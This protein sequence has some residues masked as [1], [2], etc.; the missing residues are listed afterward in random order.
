MAT[1]VSLKVAGADGNTTLRR[2]SAAVT[3]AIAHRDDLQIR[4]IV[5]ALGAPTDGSYVDDPLAAMLETA[6]ANGITVVVPSGNLG[7]GIVT[8]P[9]DDAWLLTTGASDPHATTATS[10][11]T[12]AP[13]SGS[14]HLAEGP[15]PDVVA[16][17]VSLLSLRAPG[18]TID[19]RHPEGRVDTNLFRGSGTS[20]AVA[21]TGGAAALVVQAHPDATP[22]DVKGALTSSADPIA[23]S[24]LGAVDI[25]AAI[26][27]PASPAWW[28]HHPYALGGLDLSPGEGMPWT[29]RSWTS[30]S[31]TSRSWTS[32]SWTSRSWTS[33][34]WTSRSWTSRSW[35]GLSWTGLS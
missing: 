1:L 29:S 2:V 23:G 27:A 32:R 31:W 18:S 10:D 5:L 8:A 19:R 17:G 9:G 4:V 16:P 12:V 13:F 14:G 33:R 28:Q 3:W 20:M 11:D 30:R 24:A 26:A 21:L 22:D 34:S 6:W 7:P 35:T 15:K 25:S